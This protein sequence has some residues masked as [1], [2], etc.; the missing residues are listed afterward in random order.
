MA[1]LAL[2]TTATASL[3]GISM[4]RKRRN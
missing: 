4:K 3:F 1:G 2:L